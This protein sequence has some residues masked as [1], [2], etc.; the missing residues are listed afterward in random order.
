MFDSFFV[1]LAVAVLF[2]GLLPVVAALSLRFSWRRFRLRIES[3]ARAPILGYAAVAGLP[4]AG[5]GGR[6]HRLYGRLEAIEGSDRLWLRGA[7]V[8]ALVDL[9]A[10]PLYILSADEATPPWS[11]ESAGSVERMDWKS[12]HFLSEG[13]KLFVGGAVRAERGLPV[14]TE[15]PG[16]PLVAI[17]YDGPESELVLRLVAGGRRRNEYWNAFTPAA[18]AMGVG[19]SSVLLFLS[20]RAGVLP[21]VRALSFL[22]A[23][24]PLL[25]LLPPGFFLFFAYRRLWRRALSLRMRRDLLRLPLS[26]FPDAAAAEVPLPN[27]GLYRRRRLPPGEAPPPGFAS[28]PPGPGAAPGAESG[29]TLFEPT[30]GEDPAAERVATPGDPEE[31]ARRCSSRAWVGIVGAALALALALALNYSLAFVAWRLLAGR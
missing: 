27:G 4:A 28:L 24:A 3:L 9:S 10:S 18:L 30:E 31:L 19:L 8:T 22:V 14:F 6:R 25:P 23:A 2:Y 15:A 5:S 26:R 12:V 20:S 13:T 1:I 16:E 17:L 29:W 21:S 7:G 11:P